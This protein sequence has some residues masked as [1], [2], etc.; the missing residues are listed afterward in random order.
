MT[1]GY[2]GVIP[3][4]LRQPSNFEKKIFGSNPQGRGPRGGKAT[5]LPRVEP[6]GLPQSM[7]GQRATKERIPGLGI[8][9]WTESN[10]D[11]NFA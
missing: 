9:C 5:N 1:L 7:C 4:C 11:L 8:V 3:H 10:R 2:P 6:E